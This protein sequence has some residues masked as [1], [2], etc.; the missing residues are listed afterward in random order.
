MSGSS[1]LAIRAQVKAEVEALHGRKADAMRAATQAQRRE[2]EDICARMHVAVPAMP[3]TPWPA[4]DTA[5]SGP[6]LCAQVRSAQF[7]IQQ[8][9]RPQLRHMPRLSVQSCHELCYY[10]QRSRAQRV[11]GICPHRIHTQD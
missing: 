10:S 4:P 3:P 2:L 11:W 8:P 9:W 7:P 6:A 5:P 1:P